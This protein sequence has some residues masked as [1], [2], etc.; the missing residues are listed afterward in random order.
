MPA[1]QKHRE[2]ATKGAENARKQ[3]QEYPE[4]GGEVLWG[5]LIQAAQARQHENGEELH[6]QTKPEIRKAIAS[7]RLNKQNTTIRLRQAER[8][9]QYLHGSFY[10]RD[11]IPPRV[12]RETFQRTQDLINLLIHS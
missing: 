9:A 10:H 8:A 3:Y 11:V 6:I 7:L 1:P 4:D 12:H 2:Y 5:A